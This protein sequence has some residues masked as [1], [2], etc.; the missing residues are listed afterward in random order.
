MRIRDG[1]NDTLIYTMASNISHRL[2]TIKKLLKHYFYM[3]YGILIE[4]HLELQR[5]CDIRESKHG[6]MHPHKNFRVYI[7][8]RSLKHFVESRKKEFEKR[9]TEIETID[10]L[11]FAI[12]HIQEV[13]TGFDLYEWSSP[14]TYIYS[15]DYSYVDKPILRV[16][17]EE[18]ENRLEIKSIHFREKS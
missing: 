15:K 3:E 9:H 16:I 6:D 10:T 8:R 7:S 4:Q 11:C 2:Y 1:L 18:H 14:G 12:D 17:V 5:V 13:I